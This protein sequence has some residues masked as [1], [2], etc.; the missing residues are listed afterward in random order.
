MTSILSAGC[1]NVTVHDGCLAL[2]QR[3]W[4][5][6]RAAALRCS[7]VR[8][9]ALALPPFDARSFIKL[10]PVLAATLD[11]AGREIDKAQD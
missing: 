1:E 10:S 9:A 2:R 7:G 3:A 4:T 8:L 11:G 5:A 6:R